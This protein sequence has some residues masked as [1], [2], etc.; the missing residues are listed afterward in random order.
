[1]SIPL[2]RAITHD[3]DEILD[4]SMDWSDVLTVAE[5]ISSSQWSVVSGTATIANAYNG[6]AGTTADGTVS[7]ETTTVWVVTAL[8]GD[9]QIK[10]HIT[11]SAGRQYDRTGTI[12]V[13]HQ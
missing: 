5:T 2:T 12:A 9:V 4:Y 13:R 10:N 8:L 3:P 11:T 7:G 6:S 1:M